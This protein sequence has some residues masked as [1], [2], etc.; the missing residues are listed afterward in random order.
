[1]VVPADQPVLRR[2]GS[3]QAGAS[4]TSRLGSPTSL[5]HA[6]LHNHTLLSDGRGDPERAFASM[7][8]SGLDVAALTD[9][10]SLDAPLADLL[11]AGR[12]PRGY[13]HV[14]GLDAA[15]WRR[16]AE[17]AD[18]HD[19]PG[20]FTAIRGFEWTEPVLGH[21]NVWGSDDFTE[22]VDVGRM[23][24]LYTWLSNDEMSG[25]LTGFN[26]PG[27]ERGR[28]EDFR[29]D[30]GVAERMVSLEMF[31]RY[32]DYLFEGCDAGAVSPLVACLGAGWRTGLSGASDEHEGN[33]GDN[34]GKGRTGMWV[35]EHSR[36]GVREA[37]L[38]RRFFATRS[39]G[40]RLDVRARAAGGPPEHPAEASG[41]GTTPMG[42]Q[43][44][45]SSGEV[46][47]DVDVDRGAG[48]E[49]K[50]LR[51]QVL[52]P[53]P[54]VPEMVASVDLLS[55]EVASVTV[56]VDAVDGDWVVVRISDPS[57]RNGTP[58]PDGHPC[59]DL[60]VAYASPFWLAP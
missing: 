58:G 54:V 28:F 42:G 51:V 30:A 21:V 35:T 36:E 10:A 45:V 29:F 33:W 16:T 8:A 7:R 32:D 48:W 60:G 53:G 15:G 9:H 41:A 11:R 17:L 4:R 27:R 47:F 57:R 12:L 20:V 49:G 37:M 5:L 55:G 56:A 23:T 25:A 13:L 39:S 31:N 44:P 22:V 34:E 26:H 1:M 3:T 2:I 19:E 14:P 46:R 59:N 6:D 40:L 43:L 50:P 24:S 52:R 38:A 18:S